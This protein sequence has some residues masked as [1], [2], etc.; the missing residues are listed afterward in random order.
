MNP[1]PSVALSAGS[2]CAPHIQSHTWTLRAS[3]MVELN[4]L[5]FGTLRE[6]LADVAGYTEVVQNNEFDSGW[7]VKNGRKQ[8]LRTRK[9]PFRYILPPADWMALPSALGIIAESTG[10][11]KL[12]ADRWTVLAPNAVLHPQFGPA[13]TIATDGVAVL[14]WSRPWPGTDS[15]LVH[16]SNIIGPVTTTPIALSEWCGERSSD[17]K[18]SAVAAALALLDQKLKEFTTK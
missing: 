13:V 17:T 15:M 11:R 5:P 3:G 16:R 9:P 1:N 2:A 10:L 4:G 12:H 6:A 14:L 18:A 7:G 8:W